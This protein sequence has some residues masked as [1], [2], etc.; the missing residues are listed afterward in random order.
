MHDFAGPGR[1]VK[2]N[3]T[4]SSESWLPHDESSDL[5]HGEL[6]LSLSSP[7]RALEGRGGFIPLAGS[8]K[9]D[10]LCDGAC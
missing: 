9:N 3:C 7:V 5:G 6:P 1:I 2:M 8:Q 10:E 4:G